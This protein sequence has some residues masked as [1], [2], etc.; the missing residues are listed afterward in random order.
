MKKSTL[1]L[2]LTILA[3][4]SLAQNKEFKKGQHDV[5][6]GIGFITALFNIDGYTM[7]T[8]TPPLSLSYEYGITDEFSIG[9]FI[10]SAK[11][12]AYTTLINLNT[13][14]VFYG[15]EGT[16]THTLVGCRGLY[17]IPLYQKIDTYIGAMIGYNA[18]SEDYAADNI[19]A[20][21]TDKTGTLAYSFLAGGRYR[22]S[23]HTRIFAE[24]GYGISV[25]S[26]GINFQF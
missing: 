23:Q 15:K 22:L 5:S 13:G 24:I 18:V 19:Y 6:I 25:I 2:F 4:Y 10:G 26:C 1:L 11:Q 3:Q 8:K 20:G 17:H 9:A 21:Q 16:L 12:D 7:K 14:V